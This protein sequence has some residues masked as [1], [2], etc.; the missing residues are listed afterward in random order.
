MRDN[1]N[2]S[3]PEASPEVKPETPPAQDP[4]FFTIPQLAE[5]WNCATTSVRRLLVSEGAKVMDM[6]EEDKRG[7]KLVSAAVVKKIEAK[8]TK[9]IA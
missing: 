2:S 3:R 5:R 4:A 7:K 9:V 1:Y 6:A 8:R